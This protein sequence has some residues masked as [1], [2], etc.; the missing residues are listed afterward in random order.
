MLAKTF[1]LCN[2]RVKFAK[3]QILIVFEQFLQ[4]WFQKWPYF[5]YYRPCIFFK[6]SGVSAKEARN[7][8]NTDILYALQAATFRSIHQHKDLYRNVTIL[9][10]CTYSSPVL[11]QKTAII[12]N[13]IM[14]LKFCW[15]IF[16][17]QDLVSHRARIPVLQFLMYSIAMP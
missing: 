15:L 4:F 13:G 12:N 11:I 5:L 16:W 3:C 10:K 2:V 6:F 1:P 14:H 8:N 9:P 17:S 7:V